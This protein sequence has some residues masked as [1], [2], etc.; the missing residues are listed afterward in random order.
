M[1][2]FTVAMLAV[3]IA[4]LSCV[5]VYANDNEMGSNTFELD[6]TTVIFDDTSILSTAEKQMVAELLVY[7]TSDRVTTK[8]LACLFGHKY[9]EESVVTITHRVNETQPRCLKEYFLINTCSRCGK[10]T[11]ER[12]GFMYINCCA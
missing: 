5:A 4:I 10:T 3:V 1:K 2:K 8:G 12:T 9:V 11:T 7:G 6:D